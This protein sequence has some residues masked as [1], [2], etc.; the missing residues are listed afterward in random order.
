MN[1]LFSIEEKVV[2][3]TGGTGILGGTIAAYLAE[4]GA[5]VVILGRRKEA[6]DK[7]VS[8]IG[9]KGFEA[10]FLETDVMNKNALIDNRTEILKRY[11][12]VDALLNAAGGNMPGATSSS[13]P[14]ITVT[15]TARR[16][17]RW[18]WPPAMASA[19]WAGPMRVPD[20]INRLSEVKSIPAGRMWR[21]SGRGCTVIP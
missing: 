15:V 4:E 10:I 18:L 8:E 6:G 13:P 14:S 11:G 16:T 9:Q 5:H 7:L 17:E 12:R 19:I 20:P 21:S 3:I 1:K 2:V